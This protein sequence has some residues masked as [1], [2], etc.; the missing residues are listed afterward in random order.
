[1]RMC[2]GYQPIAALLREGRHVNAKGVHG[3]YR[4]AVANSGPELI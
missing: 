4:S 2:Y 1:M 3:L